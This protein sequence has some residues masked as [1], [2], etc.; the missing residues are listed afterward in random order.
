MQTVDDPKNDYTDNAYGMVKKVDL[1][2]KDSTSQPVS[3]ES[4]EEQK[5]E[6]SSEKKSPIEKNSEEQVW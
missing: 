3:L 2:G 1:P 5:K 4:L 6:S